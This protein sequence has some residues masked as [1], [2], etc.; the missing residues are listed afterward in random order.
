MSNPFDDLKTDDEAS[1]DDAEE[2]DD[3]TDAETGET[4]QSETAVETEPK[5]DSQRVTDDQ[6]TSTPDA[7]SSRS[8]AEPASEPSADSETAAE[9]ADQSV[10]PAETGP[11]F[12]YSEVKQKP[13][14]ARTQ[15]VN[16]FENEIRTT[17]VPKLAEAGVINEE[18]REIHDAVLRL[19][20]E[21]PERIA[22][23][24]LEERRQS[25]GQ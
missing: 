11:A 20:S 22:E 7:P 21:R 24:V 8:S 2:T 23:L 10:S 5:T 12:E 16:E 18:T 19:A 14:Y 4:T 3:A 25:G 1:I 6:S 9:T 15:T 13:F 17:I